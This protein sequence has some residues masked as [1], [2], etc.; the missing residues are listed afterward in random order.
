MGSGSR[1]EAKRNR[2]AVR[3]VEDQMLTL[4]HLW[5]NDV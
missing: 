4:V 5:D 2:H 3:T 1:E